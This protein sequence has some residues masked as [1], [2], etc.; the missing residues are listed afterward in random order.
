[1]KVDF[2]IGNA[3]TDNM[4]AP[5]LLIGLFSR[6][7]NSFQAAADLLFEELSWKQEFFMNCV[8]LFPEAPTIKD[9]AELIGCSHQNAKQILSKLEKL[10]YL[11]VWQDSTDK[12]KQ[13]I[14]LTEKAVEFRKQYEIP[15]EQAMQQL[16]SGMSEEAIVSMVK[17]LSQLIANVNR[18]KEIQNEN[19]SNL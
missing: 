7:N 16:F 18:M 15:I 6:F 19:N 4:E 8:T 12:R 1:M 11:Q 13:R 5:H 10:G 14:V 9:M 3:N 17:S 2:S